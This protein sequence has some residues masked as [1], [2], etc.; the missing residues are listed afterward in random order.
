MT[1][2]ILVVNVNWVGDVIFSTPFIKAVREAYPDAYIACLIHPRCKEMLEDNP[3]LDELI[4]YDEEGEHAGLLGKARLVMELRKKRFDT[5]FILH[6]SFTKALLT[7]LA[8]IEERIGYATKNRAFVLTKAVEIPDEDIH[9]VEYFLGLARAAGIAPK[10]NSY[11]FFVGDKEKKAVREFLAKSGISENDRLVVICPGGNWDP[12]RWPKDKF[13][14]LSDLLIERFGVKVVI[15]GAKKDI[16]LAADIKKRM[17]NPAV[18]ACGTTT[19]KEL[20]ALLG[21][22]A[23]VIAN[24]TG[25]MHMA[26]AV[27]AKTIALFGP[28][29]PKLTGPYGKGEYEVISRYE[30]CDIPCYDVA[31]KDY[32]CMNSIKVEEVLEA[33][34]QMLKE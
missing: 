24:D 7:R 2:R 32:K 1:K 8:G 5:A 21:R 18:I 12:K 10:D 13:A 25:P 19:L 6:R 15:A 23:L 9:K 34:D 28:T 30:K 33:S 31:C 4:A 14:K 17:N 26:V 20:G 27:G 11:E 16:N 3:R 22:A 29:S